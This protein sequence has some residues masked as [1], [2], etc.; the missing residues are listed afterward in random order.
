MPVSTEFST[1][2]DIEWGSFYDSLKCFLN[3]SLKY[4]FNFAMSS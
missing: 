1:G 3:E 4:K 2:P